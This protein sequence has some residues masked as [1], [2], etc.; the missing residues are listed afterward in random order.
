MQ[1]NNQNTKH[2]D[3]GNMKNRIIKN[4]QKQITC[5]SRPIRIIPFFSV[6]SIKV[7]KVWTRVLQ[8]LK[9]TEASPD[10]YNHEDFND[11]KWRK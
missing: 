9:G 11:Q 7:K 10:F 3:Q 2:I 5:K 1:H 4:Q 8:T 6:Y